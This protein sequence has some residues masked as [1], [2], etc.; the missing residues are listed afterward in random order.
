MRVE[1]S[2]RS[3]NAYERYVQTLSDAIKNRDWIVDPTFALGSDSA[4][5][6]K[7]L[8]DPVTAHAIRFRKHLVAGAEVRVVPASDRAE[9]KAAASVIEDLLGEIHGF[10]DAR[11]CLAE[12]IFRGSSYAFVSGHHRR[13]MAGKLPRNE[14]FPSL[15][16]DPMPQDWWVPHRLIN[17]DRRRFRLVRDLQTQAL[18]WEFWSVERRNWE[19]M[20]NPE[21]FVRS[22][23]E[24]TEDSLG[25]GRGML[26]TLYYFQSSKARVVQDAMAASERFGQ[27]LIKVAIENMRGADGRPVG[28]DTRGGTTVAQAWQ[29]VMDKHKARHTL[30][31]DARDEVDELQ[32]TGKG[33]DLIQWLIEY[34]DNAQVTAVL[35][36]TL[37]TLAGDGGSRAMAAV[38]ENSTEAL[39]QADRQRLADDMTRDLVGLLWRLNRVQIMRQVGA[40]QM[41]RLAIDQRKKEDPE[42]AAAVISTL[43]AAGVDLRKEDVYKKTGFSQPL[44][45]DE[46]IEGGATAPSPGGGFPFGAPSP[47]PA[48]GTPINGS[49]MPPAPGT[50][51]A[52]PLGSPRQTLLPFG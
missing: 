18:R 11:M 48:F 3:R 35:G 38:Q 1:L 49:S 13:M 44:P 21:W 50:Q 25:Y 19:A 6:T 30:V 32:M 27:G 43:L 4:I 37:P 12:A 33:W 5:Y 47:G 39:V 9:D 16:T 45:G 46:I 26:D 52:Q 15:G 28:G 10:T 29:D 34:L 23:F 24:Q 42:A 41:P 20:T 31:Y 51:G 40:A 17:V 36:A 2:T 22:V 14:T 7:I 8:R